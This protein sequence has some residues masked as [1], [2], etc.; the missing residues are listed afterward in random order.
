M[1]HAILLPLEYINFEDI[2]NCLKTY[3][4]LNLDSQIISTP[5]NQHLSSKLSEHLKVKCTFHEDFDSI[6][7]L[8]TLIK[9]NKNIILYEPSSTLKSLLSFLIDYKDKLPLEGVGYTLNQDETSQNWVEFQLILENFP[10]YFSDSEEED[11]PLDLQSNLKVVHQEWLDYSRKASESLVR[12]LEKLKT[13]LILTSFISS[14]TEKKI[15]KVQSLIENHKNQENPSLP[16]VIS[17]AE[18]A[19]KLKEKIQEINE[20]VKSV[21]S[22]SSPEQADLSE[23]DTS[24][25]LYEIGTLTWTHEKSQDHRF[26]CFTITNTCK[27]NLKNVSLYNNVQS[28]RLVDFT[29]EPF[30]T[31]QIEY[32][33]MND[34]LKNDGAV[35]FDLF[36]CSF[37]LAESIRVYPV[38]ISLQTIDIEK[39]KFKVNYENLVTAIKGASVMANEVIKTKIDLKIYDKNVV[40]VSLGQFKGQAHICLSKD[41]KVISN[42]ETIII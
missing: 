38:K 26:H 42:T 8:N 12:N 33:F 21:E 18:R 15:D 20:K 32:D 4:L 35:V 39:S 37:K 1:A 31:K 28:P 11:D 19:E 7:T 13:N 40:V 6:E 5:S 17:T 2:G 27:F 36:Y 16:E 24:Q 22:L 34:E 23:L 41:N 29:I 10:T 14:S 9:N 25:P 3:K 30:Q